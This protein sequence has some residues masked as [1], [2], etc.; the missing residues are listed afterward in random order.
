M[1][2]LSVAIWK[3]L[4]GISSA[5]S[6]CTGVMSGLLLV[7]AGPQPA[8]A[9]RIK[10]RGAHFIDVPPGRNGDTAPAPGATGASQGKCPAS[11]KGSALFLTVINATV[12]GRGAAGHRAGTA[13]GVVGG[14]HGVDG[15]LHHGAAPVAVGELG[16][17]HQ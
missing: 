7:S 11:Q 13:V 15:A 12:S 4:C 17:Q 6:F 5:T 1:S 16:A 2:A 10:A 3:P 14:T 9:A 8:S